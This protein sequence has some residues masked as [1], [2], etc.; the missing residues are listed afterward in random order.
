MLLFVFELL[1]HILLCTKYIMRVHIFS[2]VSV[3]P[4]INEP[5]RARHGPTLVGRAGLGRPARQIFRGWAA[6]WPAHHIKKNSRPCPARPIMFS[7]VSARPDPSHGMR[8]GLYM[9]RFDNYVGRSIDLT[10][11]SMGRPMCCPVLKGA[12]A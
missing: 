7:K 10:G 5:I 2:R 3:I 8:Q 11:R 9:G 1:V 6:A 12:C 4:V